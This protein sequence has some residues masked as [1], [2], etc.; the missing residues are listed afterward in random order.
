M[1]QGRR[2]HQAGTLFW[3]AVFFALLIP[4]MPCAEERMWTKGDQRTK[5]VC[6]CTATGAWVV[7]A[8]SLMN[9]GMRGE[10]FGLVSGHQPCEAA[11]SAG[12]QARLLAPLH[13]QAA[14]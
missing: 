12:Y 4:K 2:A 6:M 8:N 13:R 7:S 14:A 3:S 5:L 10:M 11:M 1:D 9:F